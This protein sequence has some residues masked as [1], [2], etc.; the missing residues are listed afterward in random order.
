MLLVPLELV[1]EVID[2]LKLNYLLILLFRWH[3]GGKQYAKHRN[4]DFR[5]GQARAAVLALT[6]LG[7]HGFKI[8]LQLAIKALI[9]D[10]VVRAGLEVQAL[11]SE[12]AARVEDFLGEFA[13]Q[14]VI[15][16]E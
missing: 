12:L 16:F 1:E 6:L 5:V 9:I 11:D 3:L 2:G 7:F 10:G 8:N 13:D 4:R 14:V 15:L